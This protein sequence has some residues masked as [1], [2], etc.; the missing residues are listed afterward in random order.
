M[1]EEEMPKAILEYYDR[2]LLEA[3]PDNNLGLRYMEYLK[4]RDSTKIPYDFPE[5]SHEEGE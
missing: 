5:D 2:I 3:S 1:T 4:N